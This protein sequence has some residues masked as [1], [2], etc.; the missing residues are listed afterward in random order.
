MTARFQMAMYRRK[1]TKVGS[2]TRVT[3]TQSS[4]GTRVTQ[5]TR[6][7]GT[8]YSS[9][10]DGRGNRRITITKRLGDG[11]VDKKTKTVSSAKPAKLPKSKKDPKPYREPKERSYKL[12]NTRTSNHGTNASDTG[13]IIFLVAL[14]CIFVGLYIKKEFF[15][16]KVQQPHVVTAPAVAVEPKIIPTEEPIVL[17]AI[18]ASEELLKS[19]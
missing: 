13:C 17:E 2:M 14:V 4:K 19:E 15:E 5:S 1:T 8:T 18:Q 16:T 7:G 9:S 11:W 12:R 3:T 6:T 10:S